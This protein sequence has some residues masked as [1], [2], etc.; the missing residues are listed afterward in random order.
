[1]SNNTFDELPDSFTQ[2]MLSFRMDIC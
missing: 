2:G 1:V